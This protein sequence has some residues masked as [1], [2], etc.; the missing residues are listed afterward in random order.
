MM[1]R[2]AGSG[3]CDW[4]IR[5]GLWLGFVLASSPGWAASHSIGDEWKVSYPEPITS[6]SVFFGG[7][8]AVS[9]DTAVIGAMNAPVANGTPG[10]AYVVVRDGTA[11]VQQAKLFDADSASN[12]YFGHTVAIDGDTVVVGAPGG[13]TT[14]G[15]GAAYIY[16]RSN[17]LWSLQQRILAAD[18]SDLD[19]FGYAV[20][21]SGDTLLVGAPSDSPGTP[22]GQGSAYVYTRTGGVWS[23][24]A[25]F[26]ETVP[27]V[28]HYFGSSVALQGDTAM[29]GVPSANAYRGAVEVFVRD[30]GAWTRQARLVAADG[31][32][33]DQFGASIAVHGDTVAVGAFLDNVDGQ[34]WRGSTHVFVRNAGA[35]SLQQQLWL[36]D[37][38]GWA[39]FGMGMALEADTLLVGARLD[40]IDVTYQGT[41]VH[42]AREG[43]VWVRQ[44]KLRASDGAANDTFG[45]A[46]AL[47]GDRVVVGA[48]TE[49]PAGVPSTTDAG[50]AY[51]YRIAPPVAL[52]PDIFADGFEQPAAPP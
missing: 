21:L 17:G 31:E 48:Y 5:A 7:S 44:Q 9:G 30:A 12:S 35:W 45:H 2:H 33:G 11:W 47:S 6:S 10:A 52:P 15:P 3:R 20:A 18:G 19:Q 1:D 28:A 34:Q 8:V 41:V 39:Q 24:Q 25:K 50:A 40:S 38:G 4:V 49:E 43:G 14:Y 13:P 22:Y 42:Y 51:F 27:A 32:A 16:V 26:T 37:A 29:V 36:D 23:Q 46:L